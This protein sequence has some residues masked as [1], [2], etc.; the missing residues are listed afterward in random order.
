MVTIGS[1][2]D[3]PGLASP[4]P[5]TVNPTHSVSKDAR[6]G[7]DEVSGVDRRWLT[8]M[9]AD[10][11]IVFVVDDDASVCRSLALLIESAGW[12]FA[13][14]ASAMEFLASPE[15][16]SASCLLL[17]VSLPG[18][19]GLDL[20]QQLA[21]ERAAMPIIF[22]TGH[23]D[24]PTTVRAMKGGAMDFLTKP[25][26][27]D[28]LLPAIVQ[29]LSRSREALVD[30]LAAR[31]IQECHASLSTREREVM[32]M[33]VTGRLNKQVADE[34]GISEITVKAHRGKMM[35][36]MKARSLPDLVNM[37]ARLSSSR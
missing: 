35:R 31:E 4:G 12:R 36:K 9:E 37:A 25:F 27:A 13:T 5:R 28:V 17:D 33:V 29:A 32:T 30:R 18:I 11:S 26:R 34:L 16:Q 2:R 7:S 14:F 19:N 22:I 1:M 23:A 8:P 3:D 24:V 6:A 15:P 10:T 20:Q 21:R